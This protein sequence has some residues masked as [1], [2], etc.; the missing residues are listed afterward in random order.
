M[1]TPVI[2]KRL[3]TAE[4]F[5]KMGETGMILPDEN[6]ELIQ[7][8]IY[9]MSPIGSKHAACV[10]NLSLLL[11]ETF[12][13][14][15]L[16]WNQNPIR[17]DP[18]NEPEPDLAILHFKTDRY[19]NAL[20]VPG[21]VRIVIEVSDT[22]YEY[23]QKVKLPLY[24]TSEIPVFWIVHLDREWIEEYSEPRSGHYSKKVIHYPGDVISLSG[25]KF[26]VSD[27]LLLQE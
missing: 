20:P 6:V 4:E 18:W 26:K 16:V 19:I 13:R 23:D 17:L 2:H 1:P 27:I 5:R 8:E 24:A 11:I 21:D 22:T 9:V 10:A 7:G 15:I 3:I 25:E 12:G 14:R